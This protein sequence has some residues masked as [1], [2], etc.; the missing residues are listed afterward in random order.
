MDKPN[1]SRTIHHLNT[2][3][4]DWSTVLIP[5]VHS[6]DTDGFHKAFDWNCMNCC[7]THGESNFRRQIN[8]IWFIWID[9]IFNSAWWCL[10]RL[11][12]FHLSFEESSSNLTT[13]FQMA[14]FIWMVGHWNSYYFCLG[15][16]YFSTKLPQDGIPN[17]LLNDDEVW[18]PLRPT[19]NDSSKNRIVKQVQSWMV[20][21]T[22]LGNWTS[23]TVTTLLL[24]LAWRHRFTQ[25]GECKSKVRNEEIWYSCCSREA[26]T[27][28]S[29]LYIYKLH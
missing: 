8:N 25:N 28:T 26:Q 14:G 27:L 15:I 29:Y 3:Q 1:N 2:E 9:L 6:G 13:Y 24:H 21:A 11:C 18:G 17:M 4:I 20:L 7:I 19:G 23:Y 10:G 16:R 22:T 5:F 12:F